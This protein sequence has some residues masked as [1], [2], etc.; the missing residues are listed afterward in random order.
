MAPAQTS[1]RAEESKEREMSHDA[2][3]A[4]NNGVQVPQIGFGVFQV[5]PA[6]TQ[7][8]VERALEAGWADRQQR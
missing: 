2:A 6:E 4:L 5:P 3:V 1:E 7:G 8:A